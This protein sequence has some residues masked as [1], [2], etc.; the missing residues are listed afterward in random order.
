VS[1]RLTIGFG[2]A[3]TATHEFAIAVGDSNVSSPPQTFAFTGAAVIPDGDANGVDIPFDVAALP[4]VVSDVKVRFGGTLVSTDPSST[5][6]GLNHPYV[7]DLVITLTD[8]LARTITLADRPG[9][10]GNFGKNFNQTLFDMTQIASY[11]QSAIPRRAP[12]DGVF[13]PK[14]DLNAL[15]GDA[16]VGTWTLRVADVRAGQEPEAAPTIPQAVRS[17]S[18][19]L[20]CMLPPQCAA[21]RAYCEGDLDTNGVVD[22]ADF[23]IFAVAYDILLNPGGDLDGDTLTTDA[24]FSL[25]AVAYDRLLCE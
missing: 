2:A 24:D 11:F 3:G 8:P 5:L 15:A 16:G 1:L 4:G 17:A 9:G 13:I 10:V 14:D 21:P 22:D 20:T 6:V 18:L 25:F 12:Y 23:Q 19:I 7:G